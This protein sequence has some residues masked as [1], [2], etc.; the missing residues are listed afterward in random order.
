MKLRNQM[1]QYCIKGGQ[2]MVGVLF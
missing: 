2:H 1:I